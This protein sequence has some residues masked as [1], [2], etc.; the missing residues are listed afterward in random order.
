MCV[1]TKQ[2]LLYMNDEKILTVQAESREYIKLFHRSYIKSAL[3][4]CC[5]KC[6]IV[7]YIECF[8]YYHTFISRAYTWIRRVLMFLIRLVAV[9]CM[10]YVYELPARCRAFNTLH[11]VMLSIKYCKKIFRVSSCWR[12]AK[13][14]RINDWE[15][16]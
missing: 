8:P 2:T 9:T 4:E 11:G 5:I 14:W 1:V 15:L 13:D 16:Q 12:Q 7:M 3:S 10:Y 6:M